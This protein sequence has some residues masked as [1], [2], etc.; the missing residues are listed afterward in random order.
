MKVKCI[1]T[2]YYP[3]NKKSEL[4]SNGV[5]AHYQCIEL[6]DYITVGKIYETLPNPCS[7]WVFNILV[8]RG[9]KHDIWKECFIP[10]RDINLDKLLY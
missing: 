5:I 3:D 1:T 2:S 4:M 9:K 10:I 6:S 8:N 7:E